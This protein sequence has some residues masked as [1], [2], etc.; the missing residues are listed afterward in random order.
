MSSISTGFEIAA[1]VGRL[2]ASAAFTGTM[3]LSAVSTS[4]AV[5]QCRR[6]AQADLAPMDTELVRLALEDS[7]AEVRKQAAMPWRTP[8]V[9]A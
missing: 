6:R 2:K 5:A 7:D 9:P 3:L 1:W 4:A 8:I